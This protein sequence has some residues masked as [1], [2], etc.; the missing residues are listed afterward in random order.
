MTLCAGNYE[1]VGF[2]SLL[3]F[4]L[5]Y[6]V[7]LPWVHIWVHSTFSLLTSSFLY[8]HPTFFLRNSPHS[9][10]KVPLVALSCSIM[11]LSFNHLPQP[12]PRRGLDEASSPCPAL[13][14][15]EFS[16]HSYTFTTVIFFV[17][18]KQINVYAKSNMSD[19]LSNQYINIIFS[20]VC[21][22]HAWLGVESCW[23]PIRLM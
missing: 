7:W 4:S 17:Q 14:I 13:V 10:L 15:V 6:D 23:I 22:C 19:K 21:T 9:Y 12:H 2:F 5:V 8:C 16:K 1:W 3:S 11:V 18:P 20:S